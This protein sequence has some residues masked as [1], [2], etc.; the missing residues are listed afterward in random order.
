[1]Q[2]VIVDHIAPVSDGLTGIE[3]STDVLVI[4]D[5][6]LGVEFAYRMLV[7]TGASTMDAS[8]HC[9][10]GRVI[11]RLYSNGAGEVPQALRELFILPDKSQRGI[12]Q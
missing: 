6:F 8:K 7:Q 2:R 1:M 4:K 10:G 12:L 5:L 9:K 3:R 11:H